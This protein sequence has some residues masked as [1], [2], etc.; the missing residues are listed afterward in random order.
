MLHRFPSA[1]RPVSKGELNA[2]TGHKECPTSRLIAES[3]PLE[4]IDSRSPSFSGRSRVP[5][6]RRGVNLFPRL[7][8]E[9]RSNC[10]DTISNQAA[11][12]ESN[13]ERGTIHPHPEGLRSSLP[14]YPNEIKW[15]S[16]IFDIWFIQSRLKWR[17]FRGSRHFFTDDFQGNGLAA[18]FSPGGWHQPR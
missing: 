3:L 14:L 18:P 12:G 9:L 5:Y 6:L 10:P 15:H 17:I 4:T 11:R 13:P 1:L 2:V 7:A 16:L 8:R